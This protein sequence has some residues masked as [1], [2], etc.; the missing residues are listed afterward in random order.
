MLTCREFYRRAINMKYTMFPACRK[1]AVTKG[2]YNGASISVSMELT[3][4]DLPNGNLSNLSQFVHTAPHF[5]AILIKRTKTSDYQTFIDNISSNSSDSNLRIYPNPIID[6]MTITFSV[7]GLLQARINI[8]DIFGKS[9]HSEMVQANDG[10]NSYL[11][12][13][14]Q[15]EKGVYLIVI[16]NG[17]KRST[18][19]I[20]K[21]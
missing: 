5:G 3:T 14:S 2:V 18:V 6:N 4:V 1:G 15:L 7:S 9:V 19:K 16:S 8:F 13:I 10:T 21:I 17:S 11:C 20:V 12:N